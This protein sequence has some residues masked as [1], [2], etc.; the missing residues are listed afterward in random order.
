MLLYCEPQKRQRACACGQN[1]RPASVLQR[2]IQL[3]GMLLFL[4]DRKDE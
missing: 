4:D 2:R 1:L 3:K